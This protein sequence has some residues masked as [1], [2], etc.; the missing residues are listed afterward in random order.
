MGNLKKVK[1]P[2][3]TE[4]EVF[5]NQFRKNASTATISV[6]RGL[7]KYPLDVCHS[8]FGQSNLICNSNCLSFGAVQ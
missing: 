8:L 7:T 3:R 2:F 1:I 6:N 5:V 4:P